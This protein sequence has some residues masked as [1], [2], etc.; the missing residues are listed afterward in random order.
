[1]FQRHS[2]GFRLPQGSCEFQNRLR[3][4]RRNFLGSQ[5]VLDR[6]HCVSM[7]FIGH[8]GFLVCFRRVEEKF[9]GVRRG[10]P[11][12]YKFALGLLNTLLDCFFYVIFYAFFLRFLDVPWSQFLTLGAHF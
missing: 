5:E 6:F 4:F 9:T 10:V 7:G 11:R 3:G 8:Q 2:E 1:M 12:G